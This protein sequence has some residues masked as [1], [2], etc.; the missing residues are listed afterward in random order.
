MNR[1]VFDADRL[2]MSREYFLARRPRCLG[3]AFRLIGVTLVLAVAWAVLFRVEEVVRGSVT[4]RP[5]RYVSTVRS[6]A[7][8]NLAAHAPRDGDLVAAG[9]TLFRLDTSEIDARLATLR[10]RRAVLAARLSVTTAL[11]QAIGI[12]P[13]APDPAAA[14][15]V[16]TDLE[17]RQR[18]AEF[19]HRDAAHRLRI[20]DAADGL[21][22][23]RAKP[24]DFTTAE[25]LARLASAL[26]LAR[27]EYRAWD[28]AERAALQ[29][30]VRELGDDVERLDGEIAVLETRR[31]EATVTAP[32]SGRVRAERNL[33]PG[34]RVGADEVLLEIVPASDDELRIVIDLATHDVADLRVGMPVKVSLA[35]LPPSEF[36]FLTGRVTV[37][38]ADA[39]RRADEVRVYR[40]EGVVPARVRSRVTG[41]TIALAPGMV[42]EA[43]VVR[44][45]KPIALFVLELLDIRR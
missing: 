36:G 41:E 27:A 23:E 13:A 14:L 28:A 7:A 40:L 4:V 39:T 21:A 11:T 32:I 35:S 45:R 6:P 26:E 9:A 38:P 25:A 29:R 2:G 12:P 18:L 16:A 24:V 33:N 22:R 37:I 3:R 31:R 5:G 15:L 19:R 17:A 34:D 1:L 8:G 43:R 44:R 42:G 20:A 30:D 10:P